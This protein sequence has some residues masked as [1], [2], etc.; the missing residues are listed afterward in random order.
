MS[1]LFDIESRN[2]Q[3]FY[4]YLCFL[5]FSFRLESIVK[6]LCSWKYNER[7]TIMKRYPWRERDAVQIESLYLG[8]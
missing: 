5:A 8:T 2:A 7:G 3:G 1:D 4:S 6:G